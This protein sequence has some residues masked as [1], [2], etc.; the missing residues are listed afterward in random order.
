MAPQNQQH[1]NGL[2]TWK[3]VAAWCPS[4]RRKGRHA[5]KD[6]LEMLGLDDKL[7]NW[8]PMAKDIGTWGPR[9]EWKLN[10][11]PGSFSTKKK[12]QRERERD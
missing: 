12:R 8:M 5:Y 2:R 3:L 9:V 10:L 4:K 1:E 11:T 6:T 7:E